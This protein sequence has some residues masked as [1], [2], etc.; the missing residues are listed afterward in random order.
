MTAKGKAVMEK[1]F[2]E[3]DIKGL[4]EEIDSAVDRLFV[5][6]RAGV[7]ETVRVEPPPP[8]S[9]PSYEVEKTIDGGR[10]SQPA[11]EPPFQPASRPPS[12]PASQTRP[13]PPPRPLLLL[14]S[15][16]KVETHLLALEWEIT[17][18]NIKKAKD[19][20][21][22]FR[23]ISGE[24]PDITSV[25]GL[26]EKVL[27]HM[28]KDVENIGPQMIK[29][30]LDAKETIKLLTKKE[31]SSEISVY[32]QLAQ[33]GIEARFS[34][35]QGIDDDKRKRAD[36]SLN[37]RL[38]REGVPPTAGK[39]VGEILNKINLFSEKMNQMIE[40]F[41]QR[42]YRVEQR[43]IES[44]EKPVGTAAPSVNVTVFKIDEKFF[45]VESDKVFKLFRVP[46]TFHGKYSSQ[47]KI[48][49]K[50]FE[51]RLIDLK[52][53]LSIQGEHRKG[54]ATILTVKEDGGYKGLIV[55]EVLKKLST[56]ADIG[57][58]YGD[59]FFG[60]IHW[61]YRDHPVEIPILDLKKF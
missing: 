61:T 6:K 56:P 15:L 25:L 5:E 10:S 24:K 11:F 44:S 14:E 1:T 16:E 49:L 26:M 19:E 42:L 7:A 41:D 51:V 4:E 37:E 13:Q 23:R 55:D 36:S 9:E 38:N 54:E 39:G 27:N 60:V 18:E 47:E 34:C 40:K 50:D 21:L 29:F 35:L 20:I 31:S 58:E 28:F 17:E 53:I 32:K 3:D 22:V 48:R 52:K 12:Q 45:G 8:I 59:Y 57:R 2:D 30:L 46:S 33:L 43:I